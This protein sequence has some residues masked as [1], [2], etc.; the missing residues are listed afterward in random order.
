MDNPVEGA[1]HYLEIGFTP[2]AGAIAANDDSGEVQVR[3]AKTDWSN[4][5]END[6]FS[7]TMDYNTFQELDKV[8]VY[9]DGILAWGIEPVNDG[10]CNSDDMTVSGTS[11]EGYLAPDTYQAITS[12]TS[13]GIIES[14]TTITL[15]A[16]GFITLTEGFHAQQGSE[17]N[18]IIEDCEMA[19]QNPFSESTE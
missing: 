4:F 10:D 9:C 17:F 2:G 15:K 1:D 11:E 6:D 19:L 8:T 14:G 18:A 13:D 3:F 7:Y 12:I 5:D 16:G